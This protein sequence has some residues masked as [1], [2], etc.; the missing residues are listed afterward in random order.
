MA[1]SAVM[2]A[3][4]VVV[5][6]VAQAACDPVADVQA[7][8]QLFLR[9]QVVLG[10]FLAHLGQRVEHVVLAVAEHRQAF[11]QAGGVPKLLAA[12]GAL[13]VLPDVQCLEHDDDPA[14]DRHADQ[15]NEDQAGDRITLGPDVGKAK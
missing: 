4:G 15:G 12:Q 13:F 7:V 11:G 5:D 6:A 9:G 8:V 10:G 14:D 3:A 2:Q 1:T